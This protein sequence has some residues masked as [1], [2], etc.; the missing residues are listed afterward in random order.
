LGRKLR[1][2]CQE[3]YRT[4]SGGR[5]TNPPQVTNLPHKCFRINARVEFLESVNAAPMSARHNGFGLRRRVEA[6]SGLFEAADAEQG[7][8]D[9]IG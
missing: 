5:I 7:E 6:G 2:Q 8:L 3:A 9:F 1:R 4:C